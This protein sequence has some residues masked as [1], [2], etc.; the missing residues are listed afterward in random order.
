MTEDIQADVTAEAFG[1]LS[2]L[3]FHPNSRIHRPDARR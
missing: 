1:P 3:V 2:E